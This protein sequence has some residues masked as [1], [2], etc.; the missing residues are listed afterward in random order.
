MKHY[1]I[2]IYYPPRDLDKTLEDRLNAAHKL[3]LSAGEI[4]PLLLPE[5][6]LVATGDMD[7]SFLYPAFENGNAGTSLIAY[8][9]ELYRTKAP[10]RPRTCTLWNGETEEG[11]GAS[12]SIRYNRPQDGLEN[13]SL[14]LDDI[15]RWGKLEAAVNFIKACVG[16]YS[17]RTL[18]FQ[19]TGYQPVFP[20]K[21]PVGWMVYLPRVLSPSMVPE[22]RRLEP[23]MAA[24]GQ[25]LGTII[26]S[27]SED[28]F[29]VDNQEHLKIAHDIE[30]RLVDQD[31]LPRFPK[32]EFAS[33][34]SAAR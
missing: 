16:L 17:P 19:P 31:I 12:L 26:V 33:P 30:I 24:S 15:E 2:E 1:N 32:L 18:F 23:V 14:A 21:P 34:G 7:S 20:D 3:L 6:W 10:T 22:A 27:T 11:K 29:D 25:R 13:L 28:I 9:K 4:D 5:K 8:Y